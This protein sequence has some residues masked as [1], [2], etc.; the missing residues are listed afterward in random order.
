MRGPSTLPLGHPVPTDAPGLPQFAEVRL[1]QLLPVAVIS[2][3]VPHSQRDAVAVSVECWHINR[4]Q[5]ADVT[6]HAGRAPAV[7]AAA[8]VLA[9]AALSG[10]AHRR[11]RWV[12]FKRR[13]DPTPGDHAPGRANVAG[14]LLICSC[15]S[16]ATRAPSRY[17]TTNQERGTAGAPSSPSDQFSCLL[18]QAPLARTEPSFSRFYRYCSC[19]LGISVYV[20]DV[21]T[22]AGSRARVLT[23]WAIQAM[24]STRRGAQDPLAAL[25]ALRHAR[26]NI[27][28]AIACWTDAARDEG[29]SWARIGQQLDVTGQAV[30][31]AAIR[32]GVHQAARREAAQWNMPLPVRLPRIRWRLGRRSRSVA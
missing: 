16:G 30:R 14:A 19:G 25:R 4:P 31:Q 9:C 24:S 10:T 21:S 11:A 5:P 22:E 20:A 23:G 2:R 32:R 7:H 12:R 6:P 28:A 17:A 27:D 8:F 18:L 1:S 13:H 29:A 3:C 15:L 26:D